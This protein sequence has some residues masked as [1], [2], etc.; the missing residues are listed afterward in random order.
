M[1]FAWG[2]LVGLV[3]FPA[4]LYAWGRVRNLEPIDDGRE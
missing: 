3:T 2:F 1:T 4:L